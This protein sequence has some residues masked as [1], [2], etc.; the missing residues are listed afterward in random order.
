[1]LKGCDLLR[2]REDGTRQRGGEVR[3]SELMYEAKN[4]EKLVRGKRADRRIKRHSID[5]DLA[6]ADARPAL[7]H[8][9]YSSL[10]FGGRRLGENDR[11]IAAKRT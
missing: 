10:S 5:E 8:T 6:L 1:M 9:A 2:K 3:V 11:H 7:V 4:Q